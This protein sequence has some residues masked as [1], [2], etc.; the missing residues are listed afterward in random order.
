MFQVS[1]R[2]TVYNHSK[3]AIR[4]KTQ[5]RVRRTQQTGTAGGSI[6][7]RMYD[8]PPPHLTDLRVEP[9]HGSSKA[10]RGDHLALGYVLHLDEQRQLGLLEGSGGQGFGLVVVCD[11]TRQCG[12]G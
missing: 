3:R 12:A 10:R 2:P 5:T 9:S 1:H 4:Q 8:V 7:L 11:K 6:R